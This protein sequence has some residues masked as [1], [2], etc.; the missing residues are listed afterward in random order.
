MTKKEAVEQEL[1]LDF[2]A[3]ATTQESVSSSEF[4]KRQEHGYLQTCRAAIGSRAVA[5]SVERR[6]REMKGEVSC[7]R[8][9]CS[10]S[11][12]RGWRSSVTQH[13]AAGE[14]S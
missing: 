10:G 7:S 13:A 8:E 3:T 9:K 6:A 12:H 11:R 14:E 4:A 2:T 5:P 1:R